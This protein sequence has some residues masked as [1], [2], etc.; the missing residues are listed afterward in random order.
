[1]QN[2]CC[3]LPPGGATNGGASEHPGPTVGRLGFEALSLENL[4]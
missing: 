3:V 1:M 2:L 4:R